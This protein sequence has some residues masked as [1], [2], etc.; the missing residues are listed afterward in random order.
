MR[1]F[2][3]DEV[4]EFPN[5]KAGIDNMLKVIEEKAFSSQD[6]YFSHL[7]IDGVEVYDNFVEYMEDNI[8]NIRDV[9]IGFLTITEYIKEILDSTSLYLERAIPAIEELA[10]KFYHEADADSWQQVDNLL[11][12]IGWLIE[13]FNMID[14]LPSL[15]DIFADYEKW[16]LYSK[17]V[18]EL[19]EVTTNLEEPL[20][21]ADYVSVADIML[22][23]IK[24]ALESM[25]SNIPTVG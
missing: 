9:S 2:L 20:E 6:K 13:T 19:Q 15:A 4:M 25:R 16:N 23:E 22:Y 8:S 21:L 14:S 10:E 11:E 1:L 12:G 18:R 3:G 7:I 24:P 5:N 17:A